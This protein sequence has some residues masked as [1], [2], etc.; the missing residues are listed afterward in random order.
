MGSDLTGKAI[1]PIE[2][3]ADGRYT[4]FSAKPDPV[5]APRS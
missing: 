1:V 4:T 5:R 3:D 2:I